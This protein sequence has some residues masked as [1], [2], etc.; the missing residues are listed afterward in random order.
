MQDPCGS[1]FYVVNHQRT[2]AVRVAM[3]VVLQGTCAARVVVV[4]V[5]ISLSVKSHL[6]SGIYFCLF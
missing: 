4:V 1:F 3:V 6:T 2:C 5:L